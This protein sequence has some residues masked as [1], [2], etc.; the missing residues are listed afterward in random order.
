MYYVH[1]TK[2]KENDFVRQKYFTLDIPLMQII[3][4]IRPRSV[5][6][7]MFTVSFLG[8]GLWQHREAG[9]LNVLKKTQLVN[10]EQNNLILHS[11]PSRQPLGLLRQSKSTASHFTITPGYNNIHWTEKQLIALSSRLVWHSKKW[12]AEAWSS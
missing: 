9:V 4:V 10:V 11:K 2:T 12:D 8:Y 1:F 5:A 7:K 3:A 6:C